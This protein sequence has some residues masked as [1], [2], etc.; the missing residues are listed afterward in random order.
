MAETLYSEGNSLMY[1]PNPYLEKI[2]SSAGIRL[3]IL[4]GSF[5][6]LLLIASL[7]SLVINDLPIG[8][9]RE[10]QLGSS[11]LQNVLA[12]CLPAI[13]VAKICTKAPV[14]WLRLNKPIDIRAFLGVVIVYIISMPAMD[15]L[16]TWNAGVHFPDFLSGLEATFREW[17][18]TSNE[19]SA[20]LLSAHGFIPVLT[21]VLVIGVLTGFSEE[22]F[23]RGALQDIFTD[24]KIGNA[25]SVWIV[26]FIFSSF[27]FQFF[28]FVPR[29]LMG[30][31]FGYLLV[32]TGSLWPGCFA[33][34]LNNSVIVILA[35]LNPGNTNM[36]E[37]ISFFPSTSFMPLLSL[38]L[39]VLFF[40]FLK[41][42][43]FVEPNKKLTTW[44]RKQQPDLSEK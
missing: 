43:F 13:I 14:T 7:L 27:H 16:I 15:W 5:F 31:F 3:M 23:F 8:D 41:D 25:L 42:F 1:E 29:L 17:E 37:N 21:G 11:I 28:G 32:W 6:L 30:A 39:T 36:S 10:K 12:F 2:R 44:P 4:F 18:D 34:I 38:G 40:I 20:N 9:S 33:H 35:G 24:T 22:L 19:V 26:A